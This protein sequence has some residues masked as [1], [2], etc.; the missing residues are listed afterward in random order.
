MELLR[1]VYSLLSKVSSGTE[2]ELYDFAKKW[3]EAEAD[4]DDLQ[5]FVK[6]IIS[7]EVVRSDSTIKVYFPRPKEAKYLKQP[8]KRRLLN[9]MNLGEENALAVFTSAESS[10]LWLYNLITEATFAYARQLLRPIKLRRMSQKEISKELWDAIGSVGFT[11]VAWL[12]IF[13]AINMEYGFDDDVTFAIMK[14]SGAYIIV[15]IILALH[16][17]GSIYHFS[18][19]EGKH[20][21]NDEG[22]G[23]SLLFWFNAFIDTITRGKV[24]VFTTYTFCA[25]M[26]LSHSSPLCYLYYGLPLLDILAINPRLSNIL[27]AITSNLAPLGVTMAFGAIVIYLFSLIGFF[28]YQD[29]MKDNSSNMECSSMMQCFFTYMHYGLLSGGGIGDYISNTLSHPLDYSQPDQFYE[30]LVFDLA[31]YI[32]ILVLLVNLIMGI[33]IDSFTSLR[34]SSEKKVEIEMNTCL[35]CNET[36]DDIEYRG[37]LLGLSNNFK[38]HTE[39]DHN[40]WHYLFFIMYLDAKPSNHMNGTESFV[41][42]KLLAKEMSWIPKRMNDPAL[43]GDYLGQEN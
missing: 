40:L 7:V 39:E 38:R 28:R 14:V 21:Y 43:R 2:N 42:G 35:V 26:G 22:L 8:E 36:K 27:K 15:L 9:I 37:I 4:N 32:F 33:I 6:K 16:K 5:F 41:Y 31:F 11:I 24:Y 29:L 25:F 19:I 17:I 30:R 3:R 12:A 13:A 1:I 34:E 23:S 20:T 18:Y 10:S